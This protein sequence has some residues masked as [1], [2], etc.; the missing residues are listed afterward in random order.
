MIYIYTQNKSIE[1]AGDPTLS[2]P[3][4]TTWVIN[5]IDR[6]TKKICNIGH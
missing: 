4:N 1:I 2:L 5:E 3:W 6:I